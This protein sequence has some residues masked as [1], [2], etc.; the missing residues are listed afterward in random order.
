MKKA[1]E[2]VKTLESKYENLRNDYLFQ[3]GYVE[4]ESCEK[5]DGGY[6]YNSEDGTYYKLV[7]VR[8]TSE[9]LEKIVSL[10]KKCNSLK[11]YKYIS[12][13]FR[14]FAIVNL[15]IGLI[16]AIVISFSVSVLFIFFTVFYLDVVLSVILLGIA[17]II[18]I[19]GEK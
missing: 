12:S 7:P 16:G 19:L 8:D 2:Y 11:N 10:D 13:L 15:I 5:E 17:K 18:D 4:K 1:K 3:H 14:G 6:I 9:E